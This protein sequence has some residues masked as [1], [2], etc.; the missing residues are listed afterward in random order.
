MSNRPWGLDPHGAG[1]CNVGRTKCPDGAFVSMGAPYLAYTM[2]QL[3][4]LYDSKLQETSIYMVAS[5]CPQQNKRGV[6]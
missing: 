3:L 5:L 2:A 1:M 6:D 4:L